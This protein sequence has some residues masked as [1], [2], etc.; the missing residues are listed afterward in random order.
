MHGKGIRPTEHPVLKKEGV[1]ALR[2]LARNRLVLRAVLRKYLAKQLQLTVHA[3]ID[4]GQRGFSLQEIAWKLTRVWN[5]RVE[6]LR[7]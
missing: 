2:L 1:L 7:A 4:P 3:E 6:G 5:R